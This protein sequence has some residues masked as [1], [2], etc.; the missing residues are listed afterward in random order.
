MKRAVRPPIHI[1]LLS[2]THDAG[3]KGSGIRTKAK[4]S[5][6]VK[7]KLK[8]NNHKH[9]S[10]TKKNNRLP[11]DAPRKNE[12][13]SLLRKRNKN[14][15]K[16]V[17]IR[18]ALRSLSPESHSESWTL[19]EVII[20]DTRF[21]ARRLPR[22]TASEP[23]ITQVRRHS[24]ER[25]TAV[26]RS[27][28]G[29]VTVMGTLSKNDPRALAVKERSTKPSLFENLC[30]RLSDDE[31]SRWSCQCHAQARD[32]RIYGNAFAATLDK[33]AELVSLLFFRLGVPR[34]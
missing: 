30:R 16:T 28:V 29:W 11:F 33:P 14:L 22:A 4:N 17:R 21:W 27:V 34:G 15:V 3:R 6:L 2:K 31:R 13:H 7:S 9:P 25:C 18:N 12:Q 8:W 23:S 10:A 19:S 5:K 24:A 26:V 32:A 1:T 20:D